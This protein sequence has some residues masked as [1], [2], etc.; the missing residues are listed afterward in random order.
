M[1]NEFEIV[2]VCTGNRFRSPIAAA[3]VAVRTAGQPVRADSIGTLQ[4]RG[5]PALPEALRLGASY[6][7][8]LREHRSRALGDRGLQDAD[9]VIGF[10]VTHLARAVVDGGARPERTFLL[11]ELV[12][13]LERCAPPSAVDPVERARELAAEADKHRPDRSI[14][15]EIADPMGGSRSDYSLAAEQVWGLTSRL[16]SLLFGPVRA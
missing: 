3:L 15:L 16:V 2:F 13:A 5:H 10:E 14:A 12:E 6:G 8:D 9:L 11:A 7:V 1:G 4:Q